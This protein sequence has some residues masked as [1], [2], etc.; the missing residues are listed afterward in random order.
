MTPLIASWLPLKWQ[1]HR[2][3]DLKNAYRITFGTLHGQ[4]VLQH[5]LDTVYCQV[6]EGS[7]PDEALAF[8]AQRRVVHDILMNIDLAQHPDKYHMEDLTYAG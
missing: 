4:K 5:L 2:A 7:N 6:Y 1:T 8:N 3:E